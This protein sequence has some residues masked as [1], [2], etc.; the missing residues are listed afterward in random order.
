[1]PEKRK[2]DAEATKQRILRAAE[3]LFAKKGFAGTTMLSVSK[4][5]GA[6][7][8]LIVFHFKDKKGLY[9]AVKAS[10]MRR[11]ISSRDEDP[12]P[13]EP[14]QAFLER[15]L[16]DMYRF[17]RDNPR[18]MRL[19]AWG[20][21]EGDHEPW[22]GEDEWHHVFWERIREAQERGEI[23]DDLTPLNISIMI[24]GTVHVWWEYHEHFL[25]HLGSD[26]ATDHVDE[27]FFREFMAFVLRGLS[28]KGQPQ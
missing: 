13:D 10:I 16:R 28:I 24:C 25:M 17:Y 9:K 3:Y 19:A 4:R 2:R 21:L 26:E 20:R 22:P 15:V 27:Q 18:M 8:P 14:F 6:S 5:S 7:G 11:F 1:M 12:Q 23:R